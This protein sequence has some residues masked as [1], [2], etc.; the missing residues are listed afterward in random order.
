MNKRIYGILLISLIILISILVVI[1]PPFFSA[2]MI[3]SKL[4]KELNLPL[5]LNDDNNIQL[6]FFGYSHCADVC[7]SRLIEL[8]KFYNSLDHKTRHKL[9][10]LFIDISSPA[11]PEQS[12][13]YAQTFN[14]DFKGLNLS[15]TLVRDYT[16]AFRVYSSHALLDKTQYNHNAYLYLVERKSRKKWLRYI[17]KTVPYPFEKIKDHIKELIGETD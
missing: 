12:L 8:S 2:R 10:I 1:V 6:I 14:K 15:N 9:G 11:D 4:E 16:R 5:I 13:H 3:Q 7:I 17:Y